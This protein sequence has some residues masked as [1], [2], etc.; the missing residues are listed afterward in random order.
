MNPERFFKIWRLIALACFGLN[1]LAWGTASYLVRASTCEV[2]IKDFP[3]VS[4]LKAALFLSAFMVFFFL[5]AGR[6]SNIDRFK[7]LLK[8]EYWQN[9][10]PYGR[11]PVTGTTVIAYVPIFAFCVLT[12]GV[13]VFALLVL[14]AIAENCGYL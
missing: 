3:D 9:L 13:P 7:E 4:A 8:H 6:A 11:L 1:F 14:R 12:L 5:Y 10:R 2:K